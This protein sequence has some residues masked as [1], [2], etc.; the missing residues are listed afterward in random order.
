MSLT[1]DIL[2]EFET[3]VTSLELVPSSGGAFEIEVDGNRIFSKK[4][5]GRHAAAN[6]IKN[7]IRAKLTP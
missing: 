6:E 2:K 3:Q 1:A 7:L 4:A 5:L